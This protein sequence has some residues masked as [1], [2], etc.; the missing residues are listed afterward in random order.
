M[1]FIAAIALMAAALTIADPL[2]APLVPGGLRRGVLA[3]QPVLLPGFALAGLGLAVALASTLARGLPTWERAFLVAVFAAAQMNGLRFGPLDAFDVAVFGMLLVWIARR[4]LDSDRA[5]EL[6]PLVFAAAL[7]VL[8]QVPNLVHQSP[9]RWAVGLFGMVRSLIVAFLVVNA[10][11]SRERLRFAE[12]ALLV[13]AVASGTIAML[14]FVLAYLGIF[15]FTLIDPPESALKPTP[16]G[17]VMRAS[18]LC[19][20]A[21]HMSG[22]LVFATPVA[23]WR[24]SERWRLRD[25]AALAAILGGIL[26]SWNYG[27]MLAAMGLLGAFLFLR[28]PSRAMHLAALAATLVVLVWY[29]GLWRLLWGLSFG[30]QGVAKG[31]DQRMTLF[32]LGLEKMW[33]DPLVGTGLQ[34]FAEFSGNF[35]HRPVHNAIG[36]AATE[37]GA[38]G[39]LVLVGTLFLMLTQAALVAV[40]SRGE[41]RAVATRATLMTLALML[42]MQSEPMLDHAN[43]WLVLGFVQA[44]VLVLGRDGA[45]RGVPRRRY[46]PGD[47]GAG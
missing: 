45:R 5:I 29:T 20:T 46:I 37:L 44:T 22:F 13:L 27:A 12:S 41:A 14:Q 39:A 24:L 6:P 11:S 1:A 10:C 2:F 4:A 16:I 31:V 18:A 30:D 28:W 35:W 19:I 42:L 7:L 40:E 43:T 25:A 34:G 23:A 9:V 47:T 15:A 32:R 38:A 3:A 36:Q 21:Q 33:R 17:L 26:V 8:L